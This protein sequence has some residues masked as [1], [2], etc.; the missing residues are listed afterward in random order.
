M[1]STF[2][3][4][5]HHRRERDGEVRALTPPYHVPLLRGLRHRIARDTLVADTLGEFLLEL[6]LGAEVHM[7]ALD[8]LRGSE[9]LA[10]Q[11][12]LGEALGGE[13]HDERAE[14]VE[15]HATTV[16]ERLHDEGFDTGEHCHGV[17]LGAGGGKGDVVRQVLEII[18]TG[19]HGTGSEVV[20]TILAVRVLAFS[21]FVGNRQNSFVCFEFLIPNSASGLPSR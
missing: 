9:I 10:L 2:L 7:P 4:V 12:S 1:I 8:H 16:E 6:G 15:H 11:G 3:E 18:V 17:T 21:N 20:D 13:S 14:L 5:K 19:L